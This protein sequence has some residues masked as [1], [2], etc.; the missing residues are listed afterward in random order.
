MLVSLY[1][2]I[3]VDYAVTFMGLIYAPSGYAKLMAFEYKVTEKC[4]MG[5]FYIRVR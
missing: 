5:L 3:L 2:L 1:P 4:Q